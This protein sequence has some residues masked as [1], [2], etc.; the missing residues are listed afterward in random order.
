MPASIVRF[1]NQIAAQ[2]DHP[3]VSDGEQTVTYG[4][5]GAL[6]QRI[7]YRMT[8]AGEHPR[9]A[10]I[11][12]PGPEA[13]ATFFACLMA[14]GYYVPL[15]PRAAHLTSTLATFEPDVIV[16]NSDILTTHG[17]SLAD[18]RIAIDPRN[19]TGERLPHPL[20]SHRLA[21]VLFSE[22]RGHSSGL[23]ISRDALDNH[24]GCLL[25]ESGITPDD[26][27]SQSA[28]IGANQ[29][30]ADVFGGLCG[31]ATL[32]TITADHDPGIAVRQ[33]SLTVWHTSADQL[34]RVISSPAS[35][36]LS[37]L[38]LLILSDQSVHP[39]LLA[40]TFAANPAITILRTFGATEAG[41]SCTL[42]RLHRD[43]FRTACTTTVA[44]GEPIDNMCLHLVGGASEEEGELVISG[45]Q[46]AD[47]YWKD[48]QATEESF[49]PIE[50]GG[51]PAYFTKQWAERLN[52]HIYIRPE[53]K[54]AAA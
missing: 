15:S 27:W 11:L 52:G 35:D 42:L 24:V 28:D 18:S 46:I 1:L 40:R 48:P 34:S 54:V 38:R 2:P 43:N 21:L 32:C 47:G 41:V 37:K 13:Y 29:C 12:P 23:M 30:V 31:G 7:A 22:R 16:G 20:A 19:V 44:I 36:A 6:C 25:R 39:D 51:P 17:G 8:A 53:Q 50:E 4:E 14:G 49:R 45:S 26:R 33:G 10:A 3:A 5:L 9:V